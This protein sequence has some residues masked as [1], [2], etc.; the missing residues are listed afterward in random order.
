MIRELRKDSLDANPMVYPPTH[1]VGGPAPL[2]K[3]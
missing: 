2:E 1:T 3:H